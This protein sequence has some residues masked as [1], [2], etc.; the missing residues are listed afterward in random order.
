MS[1]AICIHIVR[2]TIDA[3]RLECEHQ[4]MT[5]ATRFADYACGTTGLM[6]AARGAALRTVFD[7]GACARAGRRTLGGIAALKAAPAWGA[8][9]AAC[10]FTD[11]RL[12]VP[13]AAF[14]N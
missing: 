3:G 6:P 2:I 10:W 8:G 11:L 5:I 13:G 9:P 14:V 1:I 12:S 4:G 7:L